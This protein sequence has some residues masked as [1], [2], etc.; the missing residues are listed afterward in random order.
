MGRRRAVCKLVMS[1]LVAFAVTGGMP[2]AAAP[3]Y[4][5]AGSTLPTGA[6]LG[7]TYQ[8]VDSDWMLAAHAVSYNSGSADGACSKHC[9]ESVVHNHVSVAQWLDWE[10]YGTRWDWRV[11][12]PGDYAAKMMQARVRSNNEI[13]VRLWIGEP[14]DAHPAHESPAIPASFS[15]TASDSLFE[16]QMFG[17]RAAADYSGAEP[18]V[19]VIPDGDRLRSGLS[20]NLWQR[21][22]VGSS[23]PSSEYY[24]DGGVLICLTNLKHWVDPESGHFDPASNPGLLPYVDIPG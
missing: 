13:H 5:P 11:L 16:A 23:H 8:R 2:A 15:V 17:W 20:F 9:W 12:K 18:F 6:V 3:T 7:D 21:L 24:G 10:V 22:E 14:S 19:L 4:N 1:L